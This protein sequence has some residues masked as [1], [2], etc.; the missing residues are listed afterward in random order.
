MNDRQGLPAGLL[1][2]AAWQERL[3]AAV[4]RH[5]VPGCQVGVLALDDEG[6]VEVRV[7]A[8][9]LTSLD[10]GVEVTADALFQYGSISKVWTTTLVMQLVDEGRLTLD[11]RVVDVLPEFALAEA[12]H[13]EAITV[14]QLLTHTSGIDGDVFTDT[15]DGDDCVAKYVE[16]LAEAGSTTRPDGPLS[17]CN[18]GFV[19]AG[20]IVEVLRGTTW[21]EAVATHVVGK[22][23]TRHAVTRPAQALLFRAAVGHL[24]DRSDPERPV[25]PAPVWTLPRSVGPAG[26]ITGSA[27][28][29]LRFAAAHLRDGVTPTGE[30]LLSAESA[31]AMRTPQVDLTARSTVDNAWGLGWILTDWAGPDGPVRAAQHG[32]HT[33]GQHAKLHAFPE[34]GIAVCVLT[35]S[36]DGA[37]L[38]E[39]LLALVGEELGLRYPTPLVDRDAEPAVLDEMLGVY[40][41]VLARYTLFRDDEGGVS[42]K[43]ARKSP[44][45]GEDELVEPPTPVRPAGRGRFVS[46]IN[47]AD[48][49]FTRVVDGED[50]YLYMYRLFR[51]VSAPTA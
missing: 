8:S 47:G 9:G 2:T 27:D 43:M 48:T 37:G 49:E 29:L 1:A 25:A 41:T 16:A 26:L 20:R 30:R 28:A 45:G 4:A 19:L 40:E 42:A 18:A 34:L 31:R 11:T 50:E 32:G 44:L 33:I 24:P 35:N 46:V 14:R 38:V 21:D 7:L 23:G 51:K 5:R 6:G 17:Y 3:D 22:L 12:G 36:D 39:E 15:G 10:T 13:A